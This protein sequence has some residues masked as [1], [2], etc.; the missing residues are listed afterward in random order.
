MY[1]FN[2]VPENFRLKLITDDNLWHNL[3]NLCITTENFV[4]MGKQQFFEEYTDHGLTHIHKVLHNASKLISPKTLNELTTSELFYLVSA[5]LIHDIAMH[6]GLKTFNALVESGSNDSKKLLEF[7]KDLKDIHPAKRVIGQDQAQVYNACVSWK[8]L[9]KDYLTTLSWLTPRQKEDIYGP[10]ILD[11]PIPKLNKYNKYDDTDKKT[12]G[13]FLRMYHHRYSH[14]IAVLGYNYG[15]GNVSIPIFQNANSVREDELLLI[16]TIARSHNHDL[17]DTAINSYLVK[18]FSGDKDERELKVKR[19]KYLMAILRIADIME[20]GHDRSGL[21]P[22]VSYSSHRSEIEHIKHYVTSVKPNYNLKQLELS[23][24]LYAIPTDEKDS[25]SIEL[26]RLINYVQKEINDGYT[27]ISEIN[28]ILNENRFNMELNEISSNIFNQPNVGSIRKCL[29]YYYLGY[30]IEGLY[31]KNALDRLNDD[32][33]EIYRNVDGYEIGSIDVQFYPPTFKLIKGDHSESKEPQK[34]FIDNNNQDYLKNVPSSSLSTLETKREVQSPNMGKANESLILNILQSAK[35]G[36]GII[37]KL[38]FGKTFLCQALF[39]Y[40]SYKSMNIHRKLSFWAELQHGDKLNFLPLMFKCDNNCRVSFKD[41]ED[42]ISNLVDRTELGKRL[43]QDEYKTIVS[44]LLDFFY[45]GGKI[46]L[47]FLIDAVDELGESDRITELL[48]FLRKD[49]IKNDHGHSLLYTKREEARGRLSQKT[50]QYGIEKLLL[51]QQRAIMSNLC[52]RETDSKWYMELLNP[53]APG[54]QK[55]SEDIKAVPF[56]LNCAFFYLR[57]NRYKKDFKLDLDYIRNNIIEIF[58]LRKGYKDVDKNKLIDLIESIALDMQADSIVERDLVELVWKYIFR[59]KIDKKAID[60]L[61]ELTG[62]GILKKYTDSYNSEPYYQ[63]IELKYRQLLKEQY[64]LKKSNIYELAAALK[65][66]NL[67]D[68]NSEETKAKLLRKLK[69]NFDEESIEF[70]EKVID[71]PFEMLGMNELQSLDFTADYL[72]SM[73]DSKHHDL[74]N[75]IVDRLC[76]MLFKKNIKEYDNKNPNPI[77]LVLKKIFKSERWGDETFK[78]VVEI[79]STNFS[80]DNLMEGLLLCFLNAIEEKSKYL[81]TEKLESYFH[82]EHLDDLDLQGK[83]EY[84]LHALNVSFLFVGNDFDINA[85]K[86]ILF[87]KNNLLSLMQDDN[88]VIARIAVFG[89]YWYRGGFYPEN[90]F[91]AFSQV[92]LKSIYQILQRN[93]DA[94]TNIRVASIL[95]KSSQNIFDKIAT[96]SEMVGDWAISI[97]KNEF[98]NLVLETPLRFKYDKLIQKRLLESIGRE[99]FL[100][101]K[102]VIPYLTLTASKATIGSLLDNIEGSNIKK[103]FYSSI[104]LYG[105]Q[106]L[107]SEHIKKYSINSSETFDL[108]VK[109]NSRLCYQVMGKDTI[110]KTAWYFVFVAKSMKDEFLKHKVGDN[111]D[112]S[113]YGKV[114]A[115][116]YGNEVPED[117]KQILREKYGFENF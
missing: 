59:E 13:E 91:P 42:F 107:N 97:S 25:I 49:I 23:I 55:L 41:S 46:K 108:I 27:V 18:Y 57:Y 53:D 22:Y 26:V 3:R 93:I 103:K 51:E 94:K 19:I 77:F 79:Y 100:L 113:D 99:D 34:E 106:K 71:S 12:I 112:I 78:R 80:S 48:N 31:L 30:H 116:G 114:I 39:S 109:L 33:Y 28:S 44:T 43:S 6:I 35:D 111:Y 1:L 92:E 10:N 14:E 96:T 45:N 115:S 38:G 84:C 16:G 2:N 67:S 50:V 72:I 24:N 75:R 102:L 88:D 81:G 62:V 56:Y 9:Y 70:L 104:I 52:C 8:T 21:S 32:Y 60:L 20:I 37:A 83:I 68:A 74:S 105:L 54:P 89:V 101:Q 85:E 4:A 40:F 29:P 65:K 58:F 69:T 5:I 7:N 63:F 117:T 95:I 47:L 90:K 76:S 73:M 64:E 15:E 11:I 87:V 98:Y 82:K 66:E 61:K 36:V 17:N 110:G 86:F